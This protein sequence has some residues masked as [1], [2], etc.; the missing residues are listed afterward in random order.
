MFCSMGECPGF[1]EL[2]ANYG[3]IS[4]KL[5]IYSHTSSTAPIAFRFKSWNVTMPTHSVDAMRRGEE[6][7]SVKQK[8]SSVGVGICYTFSYWRSKVDKY[9]VSYQTSKPSW[10]T[11]ERGR[12]MGKTY[13]TIIFGLKFVLSIATSSHVV[14]R[15]QHMVWYYPRDHVLC[16]RT[17]MTH[18][19]TSCTF[20]LRRT[21]MD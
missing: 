21:Q 4:K 6:W 14:C 5:I 20:C 8:C 9:R 19:Q 11:L 17:P 13:P 7:C 3:E 2:S 18:F 1:S 10:V 12:L 16:R 15:Q